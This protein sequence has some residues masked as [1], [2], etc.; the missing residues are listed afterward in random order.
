MTIKLE[1]FF[2]SLPEGGFLH[3]AL[4]FGLQRLF[5]LP[6]QHFFA[7]PGLL[8]HPFPP[9]F[10]HSLAQQT[11]PCPTCPTF[12]DGIPLNAAQTEATEKEFLALV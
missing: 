9:H 7:P 8:L 5:I 1:I 12:P 4:T 11:F 2:V 6:T 3:G 10:P